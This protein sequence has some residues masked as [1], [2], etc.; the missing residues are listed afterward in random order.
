MGSYLLGTFGQITWI[1]IIV[2]REILA[3]HKRYF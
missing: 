2:W 1:F 3:T